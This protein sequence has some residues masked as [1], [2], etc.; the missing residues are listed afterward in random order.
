MLMLPQSVFK[1]RGKSGG[2]EISHMMHVSK[3]KRQVTNEGSHSREHFPRK[4]RGESLEKKEGNDMYNSAL[5][6]NVI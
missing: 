6:H 4:E 1:V 3:K 5:S 2:G